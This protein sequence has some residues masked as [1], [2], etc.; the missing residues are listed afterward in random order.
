MSKTGYSEDELAELTDEEREALEEMEVDLDD[1]EAGADSDPDEEAAKADAGDKAD[2]DAG[3]TDPGDGGDKPDDDAEKAKAAEAAADGDKTKD[4]DA[5][6]EEETPQSKAPKATFTAPADL[7]EKRTELDGKIDELDKQFDEGEITAVEYRA[8]TRKLQDEQREID[9]QILRAEVSNDIQKAAWGDTCSDFIAEH[10]QY[11]NPILFQALDTEVRRL[12]AETNNSYDPAH[13]KNAHENIMKAFGIPAA[14]A[15]ADD[16]DKQ[17]GG[18]DKD[19]GK[20]TGKETGLGD[21]PPNLAEVPASDIND[22]SGGGKFAHL[23]RLAEKD[24]EAYEEALE[25]MPEAE[26]NAYLAS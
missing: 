17:D 4:D 24:I 26:R 8:E 11:S 15:A 22:E 2:D 12:Q 5:A 19:K 7:K 23:D 3:D 18:K 1:P 16:K 14:E 10:T 20:V 9:S 25:K 21:V 13:L 6:D